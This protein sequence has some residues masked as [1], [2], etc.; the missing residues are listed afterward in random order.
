MLERS[1]QPVLARGRAG[2]GALL[3]GVALA[4]FIAATVLSCGGTALELKAKP[5]RFVCPGTPITLSWQASRSPTITATPAVAGL[6]DLPDFGAHPIC[7]TTSTHFLIHG[8][9]WWWADQ[10]P[11][12]ATVYDPAIAQFPKEGPSPLRFGELGSAV[13]C[14]GDTAWVAFDQTDDWDPRLLVESV[15]S[16]G[17]GK[18]SVW[19]GGVR[20]DVDSTPSTAFQ[21]VRVQGIWLL[22]TS[23][24]PRPHAI[25]IELTATCN[26]DVPCGGQKK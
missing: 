11:A 26:P 14:S 8:G 16:A 21:H 17:G 23:C 15:K 24:R 2:P 12:D 18:V 9:H 25:A 10:K 6:D 20:A 1:S 3:R 5:D 22:E 13:Q 4:A 19:H 7:L